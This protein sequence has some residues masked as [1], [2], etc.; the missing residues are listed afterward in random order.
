MDDRLMPGGRSDDDRRH[1][2]GY[3]DRSTHSL[4][5]GLGGLVTDDPVDD[6]GLGN[7]DRGHVPEVH[8]PYGK[9][10]PK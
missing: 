9:S 10:P 5:L 1:Y 6:R 3:Q 2:G 8:V 7:H 4:D